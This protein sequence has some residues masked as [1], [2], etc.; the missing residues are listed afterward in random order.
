MVKLDESKR[1]RPWLP[2]STHQLLRCPMAMGKIGTL[3]WW[4]SL[5]GNPYPKNKG[6]DWARELSSSWGF[7]GVRRWAML[8]GMGK[9][10]NAS[11]PFSWFLD[12]NLCEK[13]HWFGMNEKSGALSFIPLRIREIGFPCITSWHSSH[14]GL[15][16][17]LGLDL[18]IWF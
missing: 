6:Y 18:L 3:F 13:S 2:Q 4:L 8:S 16:A 1:I 15:M 14:W 5:K 11:P 12:L 10:E 7:K 9:S 17:V